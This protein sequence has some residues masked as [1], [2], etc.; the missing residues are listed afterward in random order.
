M[1]RLTPAEAERLKAAIEREGTKLEDA[2]VAILRLTDA[3]PGTL[4]IFQ[5]IQGRAIRRFCGRATGD[6]GGGFIG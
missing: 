2:M 1:T 4:E 3:I 5:A 6:L